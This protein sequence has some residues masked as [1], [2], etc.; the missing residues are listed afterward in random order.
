MTDDGR[1]NQ[2]THTSRHKQSRTIFLL[3]IFPS[4]EVMTVPVRVGARQRVTVGCRLL[5]G[6][7]LI[8]HRWGS[9]EERR[10]A[11]FESSYF[12]RSLTGTRLYDNSGVE[13]III[14]SVL[15]CSSFASLAFN[16][17]L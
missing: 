13:S 10:F 16:L 7:M 12:N 14:Q 1:P 15:S 2:I 5:H 11:R 6:L 8:S 4:T 17:P 3:F 9:G